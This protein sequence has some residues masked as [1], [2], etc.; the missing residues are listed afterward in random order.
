MAV[1]INDTENMLNT[2]KALPLDPGSFARQT[3]N[4]LK[5]N[6]ATLT[7]WIGPISKW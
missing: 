7:Y 5:G 4:N 6:Y 1:L 2:H 3:R